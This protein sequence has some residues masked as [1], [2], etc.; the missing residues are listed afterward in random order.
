[1]AT[2]FYLLDHPQAV[3]QWGYP[4]R[5][6]GKLSGTCIVHTAENV[7]DLVGADAGAEDVASFMCR[8][9]DYGA[10]HTLVDSDS[11]MELVPYEYECW[12]DSETNNW[13]VGISAALQA[14]RWLEVPTA[15]R[16]RIYRNLAWAAADFVIYMRDAKKITVPLKRISGA[17]ARARVPGFCAHGDSGIARSDPGRNFNWTLFFQYT[18][19]EI[20]KR[21]KGIN[22]KPSGTTTSTDWLDTVDKKELTELLD[23]RIERAIDRLLNYDNTT[24]TDRNFY[25]LQIDGGL[26][27]A[28]ARE[29]IKGLRDDAGWLVLKYKGPRPE[30]QDKPDV[31]QRINDMLAVTVGG[32]DPKETASF[33]ALFAPDAPAESA[34]TGT[35]G[36][37]NTYTVVSGDTLNSIAARFG[38]STN[39]LARLNSLADPNAL[40]VGQVLKIK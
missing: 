27:A 31:F 16:L 38:T 32:V 36:I 26:N 35:D 39:E 25:A 15:R 2:G 7:T 8:R 28:G 21:D 12:Q 37:P 13:A 3:Q 23:Q 4:R 34:P 18:A 29:D 1:M 40:A 14:H 9:F 33:R 22:V 5:A 30:D 11:I 20:A 10:Y 17:Q 19:E 24:R 6:G